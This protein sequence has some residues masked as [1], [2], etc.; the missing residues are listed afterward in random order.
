MKKLLSILAA[1]LLIPCIASAVIFREN[2]QGEM[3][4]TKLNI[5]QYDRQG[6]LNPDFRSEYEFSYDDDTDDLVKVVWTRWIKGTVHK[7]V[8][9]REGNEL[10]FSYY[11]DDKLQTKHTR[12]YQFDARN[13]LINIC[14]IT[15]EFDF[16]IGLHKFITILQYSNIFGQGKK[17]KMMKLSAIGPVYNYMRDIKYGDRDSFYEETPGVLRLNFGLTDHDLG[18]KNAVNYLISNDDIMYRV[19]EFKEEQYFT[20]NGNL[21]KLDTF[22][23]GELSKGKGVRQEYDDYKN[24]T[25]INILPLAYQNHHSDLCM[26]KFI[27]TVTPWY[28][29][30]S[31][32]LPLKVND[33]K[34]ITFD[35]EINNKGQL[36]QMTISSYEGMQYSTVVEFEYE[37]DFRGWEPLEDDE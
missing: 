9:Q 10:K 18:F 25:N 19:S 14:K 13:N 12:E 20:L 28:P 6:N 24:P 31:T 4:V 2:E 29:F 30:K 16:K 37:C 27:E 26:D 33:I 35:Y 5:T 34:N 32:F 15:E 23:L 11:I 3:L 22:D 1:F 7:E 36:E 21:V 8:L 17:R